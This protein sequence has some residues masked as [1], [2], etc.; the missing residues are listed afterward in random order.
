VKGEE[1]ARLQQRVEHLDPVPRASIPPLQNSSSHVRMSSGRM[2]A[3]APNIRLLPRPF[4]KA[5]SAVKAHPR[6]Y[7]ASNAAIAQAIHPCTRRIQGGMRVQR[8][9]SEHHTH[10]KRSMPWAQIPEWS[11]V[12]NISI[13]CLVNT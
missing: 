9:Q 7:C 10:T 3:N 6:S 2:K 12:L 4:V 5:H 11:V 8:V 1:A 13:L